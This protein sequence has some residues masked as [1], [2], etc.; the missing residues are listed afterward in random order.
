MSDAASPDRG[1]RFAPEYDDEWVRSEFERDRDRI[2]YTRELRRLKDVTQVARAGESYLYHDRLSHSLKVAQVGRGLARIIRKRPR[3]ADREMDAILDP[4]VVEAA[5]L[6]HDLGHPPF[7]HL[8]ERALDEKAR[9]RTDPERSEDVDGTSV[10]DWADEN[11]V[12]LDEL[13]VY[14]YEG[15]AQSFRIVTRLATHHKNPHAGLNLTR[16][17]LNAILKYPRAWTDGADKWGY[18][19]TETDRFDWARTGVSDG[20]TLEAEVMDYADDVTYAIHDV[21]DFYKGGL[22][23][24]DHLLGEAMRRST[25]RRRQAFQRMQAVAKRTDRSLDDVNR[26]EVEVPEAELPAKHTLAE[27]EDHIHRSER[28][29]LRETT[30]ESF[31]AGLSGFPGVRD[32][33]LTPFGGTD[34]ERQTLSRLKSNLVSRYL[35]AGD[36]NK[37]AYVYLE[38][39][40]DGSSGTL[41]ID[42]TF[43]E[44]VFLLKELTYYYVISDSSLIGQQQGQRRVVEELFDV[45][46]EEAERED[47]DSSAIP[48]PYCGRL[49]KDDPNVDWPSPVHRRARI[50]ADMIAAMTEPQAVTLHKR[51]TG[52]TPGSLQD[53]IL[54]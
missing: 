17:T 27:F 53:E 11:D 19:P 13:P 20:R 42:R 16:A 45:L 30:V 38:D 28:M 48:E 36:Q 51:L 15:N 31:F 1:D 34:E 43:E 32:H 3:N 44:Q 4:D 23:P 25:A 21:V 18:Y 29:D 14:G 10:K 24:L 33:L 5:C 39:T 50:V 49:Q 35:N 2:L 6:A 47:L 46:Y 22:I 40:G 37:P 41:H 52:D 54:R 7:G 26:N 12:D 8:S 9:A